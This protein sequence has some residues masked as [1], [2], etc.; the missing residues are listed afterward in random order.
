MKRK[1]KIMDFFQAFGRSLMLP[2]ATL[3]A[4]GILYGLTAAL[5]R[6]QVQAF[7]PFLENEYIYYVLFLI[8]SMSSKVF[9]LIPVLFAI[10]ISMGLAKKEKH[11]AAMAGFIGYYIMA[12]S[13]SNIIASGL[14]NFGE[15]G[16]GTVLGVAK[17]LEMGAIGGMT[18]GI[19]VSALHNRFY[20]IELPVAI[21]FFGGKRFVSII[22][23]LAATL[24][25]QILPFIWIPISNVINSVGYG[26]A[27]LGNLGVFLFGFFE[28]LLI[29][30][31][32]HHILNGIFRTTSVGGV[33]EGIEGVWNIFFQYFGTVDIEVLK[34]FTVYMAQGK[35]PYMVFG[36]PAAAYAIY[37]T[38]KPEKKKAVKAL[39]IAGVLASFT[40]GITEPLEFAFLFVAPFLFIFHSVMAGLSF[41]LM[42]ILNV[43]IGNTQGGI[44]D[45][46]VYGMMVPGSNWIYTV[47]VGLVYA[48]IY[49]FVF[50]WYLTKKNIQI[51][52][53]DDTETINGDSKNNKENSNKGSAK[54]EEIIEALGGR[55]NI[56]EVNNCFTRLR[57][58]IKDISKTDEGR[59]KSTGAVGIVKTSDTHIQVI[60]GP[61]VDVIASA[62]KEAL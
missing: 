22:V 61:K 55:E 23:V 25:G 60:Y 14:I 32:L 10:S 1:Q 11:I 56:V 33:Y 13:A 12:W 19:L 9:E 49:Y 26:I 38:T 20:N 6:P 62:V 41:M 40:T 53:G 4:V 5:S 29:P 28:R 36:L 43:G 21:A 57:V 2:I 46:V 18:A 15:V 31:G 3:A 54:E 58:D 50:K 37:K 51:Q 47:I 39:L 35:I 17:T 16:L 52:S 59:L 30:T 24:L 8:R 42:S 44:I 27:N 45:L 48:A 34:D 7:L